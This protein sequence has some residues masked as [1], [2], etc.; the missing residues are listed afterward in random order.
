MGVTTDQQTTAVKETRETVK[1]SDFSRYTH[2][3]SQ[4]C[5]SQIQVGLQD[6]IKTTVDNMLKS[7]AAQNPVQ[8]QD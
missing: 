8:V 1:L 5:Q 6:F 2:H 7:L 3:K 4:T